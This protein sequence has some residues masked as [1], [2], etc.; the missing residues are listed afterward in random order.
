[1]KDDKE[2]DTVRYKNTYD[3]HDNSLSNNINNTSEEKN[4]RIKTRE[5]NKLIIDKLYDC[6]DE[7]SLEDGKFQL[8]NEYLPELNPSK[9]ENSNKKDKYNMNMFKFVDTDDY[10]E[11]N[12]NKKYIKKKVNRKEKDTLYQ[13]GNIK[14]NNLL[15]NFIIDYNKLNGGN[16]QEKSDKINLETKTDNID[17][18]ISNAE[19]NKNNFVFNIKVQNRNLK[20][21]NID[22]NKYKL[23]TENNNCINNNY[24]VDEDKEKE[25]LIT[26]NYEETKKEFFNESIYQSDQKDKN[27]EKEYKNKN[28]VGNKIFN[29]INLKHKKNNKVSKEY[30]NKSME[31]FS[32]TKALDDFKDVESNYNNKNIYSK[33][34][35]IS[36]QQN[37]YSKNLTS[38]EYESN[39]EKEDEIN[40][41]NDK[42]DKK[43][44]NNELTLLNINNKKV[45]EKNNMNPD[46]N[47]ININNNIN[48]NYINE[49]PDI[50]SKNI[51]NSN[52]NKKSIEDMELTYLTK[53]SK[54]KNENSDLLLENN[55]LKE[56]KEELKNIIQ[57]MKKEV[58]DN[59]ALY[60]EINFEYD[61]LNKK[62]EN[63]LKKKNEINNI[64]D[65]KEKK[66][67]K[68][69]DE[70]NIKINYLNAEIENKDIKSK[71]EIS[72]LKQMLENLKIIHEQMKD[73]YDLL[74]LKMNVINQENFSLKR[75]LYF[76]QN[77]SNNNTNNNPNNNRNINNN[78]IINNN[79]NTN[80]K[81]Y[82]EKNVN[83]NINMNNI[84]KQ[85]INTMKIDIENNNNT[86]DTNQFGFKKI[87]L[88]NKEKTERNE[89]KSKYNSMAI[90]NDKN[91][92]ND[93][94]YYN[95][96]NNSHRKFIRNINQNDSSGVSAL[97]KNNHISNIF[98]KKIK[99]EKT[100]ILIVDKN[101]L[102]K[103]KSINTN[104][105]NDKE[106]NLN[107]NTYNNINIDQYKN[108]DIIKTNEYNYYR[109]TTK[110]NINSNKKGKISRTKSIDNKINENN[111]YIKIKNKNNQMALF[112]S[113]SNL[114][115]EKKLEDITKVLIQL[116]KKRDIY[117]D[118]YD[119]LPEHPKKQKDLFDKR[120]TK[121]IIDEL[122]TAINE[123][124]MKERS[125]KKMIQPV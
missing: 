79:F 59:K 52:K 37:N 119:K 18:D 58:I 81:E 41:T 72:Q 97:L 60:N 112:P 116:Q 80:E 49:K 70:L 53:L 22:L 26:N 51:N 19:A 105:L 32:N 96:I 15:D 88:L 6:G 114:K 83:I 29:R 76:Y 110:A 108:E 65:E 64:N 84:P 61:L 115:I 111:N 85:K 94:E 3:S 47:N 103:H 74:I 104:N 50:D 48:N 31:Y 68:K 75:E 82:Q 90:N 34:K 17:S 92:N 78:K 42:I 87:N 56:E 10:L 35:I 25:K 91:K 54:L 23:D 66:L 5:E 45:K 86:N 38:E 13:K 89:I 109:S 28:I 20:G 36:S 16:K 44:E 113:E 125:L 107:D 99:R 120:E 62:Y 40:Q 27:K 123:Y 101:K 12:N 55:K 46:I 21:N 73:Q 95:T 93:D 67:Q 2:D 39:N 43:K 7:I 121:K 8:D 102:T 118:Q 106:I 4:L 63:L 9:E 71:N 57:N 77:S 117:L 98:E 100:P 69:I 11:T 122:N 33:R 14:G 30:L 24:S 124:K 1:M